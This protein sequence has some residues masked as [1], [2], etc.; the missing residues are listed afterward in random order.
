M[1]KQYVPRQFAPLALQHLAGTPRCALWAKP[2]MGKTVLTL[3][4]LEVLHNVMGESAPTLVLAPLRVA[5]DG[6]AHESSKWEHLKGFDVVPVTGTQAERVAALRKDA[7]VYATN[8]EN[9]Q[10]L[11]EHFA[12][13]PWPFR[14]VVAD[15][16]TK[17]KSFRL[18]QGSVRA[19]AIA[20][21]AH[22]KIER[23]IN[24]TGTPSPNGLKDL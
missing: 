21:V 5:R 19:Q 23:W 8:Y 24:L 9:L 2:G 16:S 17:L 15:E 14:T 10:W 11:V 6:W 1:R 18:R 7:P 22:T 3:S 20:S 13:K 4:Y 12:G